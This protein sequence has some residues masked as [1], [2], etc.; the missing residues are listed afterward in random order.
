[1]ALSRSQ[2]RRDRDSWPGRIGRGALAGQRRS[3]CGHRARP[4]RGDPRQGRLWPQAHDANGDHSL[5]TVKDGIVVI[6]K[7]AVLPN[8]FVI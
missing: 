2:R 1:M 3:P 6:K 4:L 5:Y 7:G 8:G